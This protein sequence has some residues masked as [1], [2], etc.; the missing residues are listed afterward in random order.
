M[1]STFQWEKVRKVKILSYITLGVVFP[2]FVIWTIV[3]TVWFI[4]SQH[5][6]PNCIED[7]LEA[8]SFLIFWCVLC[9]ILIVCY[10]TLIAYGR[11][12]AQR[13]DLMRRNILQLLR[14]IH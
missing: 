13:S 1:Q 2:F 3:G 7:S 9:Y 5:S 12:M 4:Q 11:N 8:Y 10:A 6:Q 14:R